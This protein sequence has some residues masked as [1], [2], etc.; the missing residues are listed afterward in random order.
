M[1]A[2]KGTEVILEL[3]VITGWGRMESTVSPII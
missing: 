1:E 3:Q 2:V